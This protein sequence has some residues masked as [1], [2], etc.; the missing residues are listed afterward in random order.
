MAASGEDTVTENGSLV[1]L[2]QWEQFVKL[3]LAKTEDIVNL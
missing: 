1:I 2:R 3:L